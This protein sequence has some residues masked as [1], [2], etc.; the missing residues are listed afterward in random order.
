MMEIHVFMTEIHVCMTESS[1][2]HD[3]N[4]WLDLYMTEMHACMTKLHACMTEK[5]NQTKLFVAQ[6]RTHLDIQVLK[7][8]GVCPQQV[9]GVF[10]HKRDPEE[11]PQVVSSG[12]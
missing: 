5:Q 10:W 11:A 7:R 1:C 3:G 6:T 2:L 4:T 8:H 12:P 9:V